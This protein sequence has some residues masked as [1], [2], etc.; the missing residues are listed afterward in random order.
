MN[1]EQKE[2][3]EKVISI[4]KSSE[5]DTLYFPED[6]SLIFTS[7]NTAKLV[8]N[9]LIELGLLK[10]IDKG[11]FRITNKGLNFKGFK[12]LENKEKIENR[13]NILD[14]LLKEWQVKTFWWI[15]GFAIIG[16]TLSVYNFK[17]SLTPSKDIIRQEKRIIKMELE[18]SKLRT[19]ILNQKRDALLLH[20][21]TEKQK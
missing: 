4:F 17:I 1:P 20:S 7:K 16:F 10:L 3:A 21:N 9:N 13:K 12:D 6:L 15:F 2:L 18:L 5:K 14:L 19:L 8:T 11:F